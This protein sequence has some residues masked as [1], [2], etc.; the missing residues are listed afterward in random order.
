MEKNL[1]EIKYWKKSPIFQTQLRNFISF[2]TA[3]SSKIKSILLQ[4]DSVFKCKQMDDGKMQ[5]VVNWDVHLSS[6]FLA[7]PYTMRI[8]EGREKKMKRKANEWKFFLLHFA[9]LL[10]FWLPWK[11]FL[12]FLCELK[13][14]FLLRG[15]KNIVRNDILQ[16]LIFPHNFFFAAACIMKVINETCMFS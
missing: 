14:I 2:V 9:S 11:V 7:L 16:D 15:W 1:I 6:G 8:T 4:N 13:E 10:Q 5:P 3:V 12:F